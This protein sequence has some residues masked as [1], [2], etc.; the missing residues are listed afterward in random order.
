LSISLNRIEDAMAQFQEADAIAATLA[1]ANPGDLAAQMQ[2]AKSRRRLG[3]LALRKLGDSQGAL[4]YLR[5][6]L[7]IHRA[8]LAQQ[9]D[10]D[11]LKNEVANSLGQLAAAE[12]QLG[13]LEPAR[14]LYR[15]EVVVRESFTPARADATESRRELAGL[16]E[17]LADLSFRMGTPAEGQRLYDRC[18]ELREQV[19]AERPD[20]WPAI[21]DLALTYNNAGFV[22][23]PQGRDPAGAR[24]FHRK[25]V[26]LYAQRSQADPADQDVK[27]RLATTLYYE[28][29]CALHAGD[30][31]GAA[32]G[33]RRC[34]ELRQ[35]LASDPKAKMSQV[36]LMV[37]LARCGEHAQAARIARA[38]VE[39]P[40]KDEHLYFQ[41]ACGYA[42]AAGATRD[43]AL[44]R[45]YTDAALACLREGKRHGWAD[46]GSLETDPD[47]EPI[48]ADPAFRALLAE[49][50]RSGANRP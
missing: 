44:A 24:E 22:R 49:F 23:Y 29:T 10:D 46:V 38:L 43:A 30:P 6:A 5:Q 25:A 21:N 13:H 28:A 9:P 34:L 15:E 27:G 7:E 16:Y 33:Y 35:A 8:C 17:R 19:A 14:A 2:V 31:A 50:R 39:I 36:D 42:L 26:A 37:A 3:F 47:L 12:M 11:G 40:P 1:A 4:R 32:A 41:A 45:R 48:R 18:A 20:F